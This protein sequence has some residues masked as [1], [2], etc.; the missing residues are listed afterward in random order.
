MF[1]K[2]GFL[3]NFP[4]FT[5]KYL[6]QRPFFNKVAGSYLSV[7]SPNAGKYGLEETLYLDMFNAISFVKQKYY[8][9]DRSLIF[10]RHLIKKK[11]NNLYCSNKLASRE[12]YQI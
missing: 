8:R 9:I 7:F 6:W 4:K 5:G 10:D 11:K 2:K 12:V 1:C 3:G